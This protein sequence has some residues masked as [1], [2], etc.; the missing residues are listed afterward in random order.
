VTGRRIVSSP[1]S[2]HGGRARPRGLFAPRPRASGAPGRQDGEVPDQPA[3]APNPAAPSPDRPPPAQDSTTADQNGTIADQSGTTAGQNG[4]A[5]AHRG[6]RA[7][8]LIPRAGRPARHVAPAQAA[9]PG[10]KS[11]SARRA[12]RSRY[13]TLAI[14]AVGV[15]VI[16]LA[17]GFGSELSAEPTAQAFLYDWQQQQYAAAAALTTATPETAAATL[18]G[19]FSQLDAAQ[20]LLSM[21]SVVQHGG[22]ARASFTATVDLAQQGRVWTYN[23]Q[24]GLRRA[25]SGWKVVWAPNVINPSLGPAERLAVVT[26]FP[27][28]AAVL[29]AEGDPLQLPAPAYV[30]GVWPERLA[31]QA[32]T[33]Q[34]FAR[35]TEL[36]T[37]QVLGLIAAAP[38]QQFLRLATLDSATYAKL[39]SSLHD[40]PGLVVR[41]ESQ[42]LFQAKATGLVGEVGSEINGRLR[43]DGALYAPGTTVG[44]SGL[45]Q[46]YQ[47]RLL[48]TPTTEVVVVNSAGAQTGILAQWP[49]TAGTPVRTTIDPKAQNAAL[50]ALNGVSSSGEIVAVQASTGKVLAVGQRQGAG[51]LPLA[52]ALN[53]KLMPGNAFTIVSAGALV[54]NDVLSASTP[55]SCASSLTVAG[56]TFTS[57]G[58]GATKPFSTAFAD[59]C[60]TAFASLSERL[61]TSQ[62]AQAVREF[63]IGADWSQLQVPAFSGSVPSA[64]GGADLAAQIIGQGDVRMSLLSMAMVAAAVDAGSWHVPQVIQTLPAPASTGTTLDPNMMSALQGLMRGA[65]RSGAAQAASLPGAQVYGQVGMVHAGSGWMSWFVGYRADVAIAAIESGKTA[66]LSAAALARA[67]FAALP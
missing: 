17:T 37:G 34:A 42:R 49:G 36:Q 50:T 7:T 58:S 39:R 3:G 18:R 46:T 14:V 40:V 22:T 28:R 61:T 53:A 64:A 43:A 16:G 45:E 38:P 4:D 10:R 67:F 8:R 5:P 55:I 47:R 54:G 63:G 65:V 41:P 31:D 20:L 30:L 51:A 26:Q 57:Y 33:A 15:L 44:L 6:T 9:R 27:A 21:K 66:K 19:A 62:W 29:D 23:G 59:G 11:P 32:A 52:G 24:F 1:A 2:E 56:Q 48:G 13:A 25:G 12:K 60:T 35:L